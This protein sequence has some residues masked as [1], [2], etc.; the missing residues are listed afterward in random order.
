MIRHYTATAFVVKEGATLLHWHK[1]LQ[2]WMPPGGHVE[3]NEDPVQAALREVREET[4]VLAEIIPTG[5]R[6]MAFDY[7]EQIQPPYTILIENIPGQGEPHQHIDHIYFVRPIDAAQHDRVDDPT[8]RWV[9][10]TELNENTPLDVAGCGVS[11]SIAKDV[12]QLA[13]VAIEAAERPPP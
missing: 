11:A 10:A 7:P 4:G 5:D 3:P 1:R 12:R 6:P 13:L 9:T 8:L 2:Q